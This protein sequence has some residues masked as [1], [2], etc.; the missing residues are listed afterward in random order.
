MEFELTVYILSIVGIVFLGVLID[1]ILPDGEINKFVKGAFSLI[2]LLV[3]ISPVQKL[4]NTNDNIDDVFYNQSAIKTDSDFLEATT[5]QL[6][7]QLE[8]TLKVKLK[9]A[10]FDN[11]SVEILCDMSEN[12][13]QIKKVIIDISKMVI[14]AN[15]PHINKYV[16]IKNVV[17][18]YLNVEESDVIIN[19]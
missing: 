4:F 5:K 8:I 19:E 9:D 2:A 3:I 12:V 1:I 6:K 11:V 7:S 13:F 10:G 15:I 14:N 17:I 18:E 16:E